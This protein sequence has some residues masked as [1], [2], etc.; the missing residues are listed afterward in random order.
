MSKCLVK[1]SSRTHLAAFHLLH[2][3]GGGGGVSSKIEGNRSR[4]FVWSTQ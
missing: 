2:G 1:Y 4:S 3:H